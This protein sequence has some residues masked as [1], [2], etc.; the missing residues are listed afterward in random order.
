LSLECGSGCHMNED[1]R[2]NTDNLTAITERHRTIRLGIVAVAFVA[3]VGIVTTA[4]V[5]MAEQPPW[6]T[7]LLA[8]FGPTGT[9]VIIFFGYIKW[10]SGKIE[11][12]RKGKRK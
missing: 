7:L 1:K 9:V 3:T 4:V 12:A 5:K 11:K 2:D 10:L 6:L 8:I